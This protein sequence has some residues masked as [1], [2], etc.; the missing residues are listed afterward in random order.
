MKEYIG[1]GEYIEKK[2]LIAEL[3]KLDE[4]PWLVDLSACLEIILD[5]PAADVVE[6]KRGEWMGCHFNDLDGDY[7]EYCSNCGA[8]SKEYYRPFCSNCGA[9]MRGVD[10]E[11]V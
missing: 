5:V 10:H 6:R 3:A 1:Q 4:K 2:A 9:D 11:T 8:Y 7:E